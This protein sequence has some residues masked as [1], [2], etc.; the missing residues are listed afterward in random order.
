MAPTFPCSGGRIYLTSRASFKGAG[1]PWAVTLQCFSIFFFSEN[2]KANIS[3]KTQKAAPLQKG[4]CPP[5][6]YHSTFFPCALGFRDACWFKKAPWGLLLPYIWTGCPGSLG[7]DARS[8]V[9]TAQNKQRPL[10]TSSWADSK[11][12]APLCNAII[13]QFFGMYLWTPQIGAY[14]CLKMK[15]Y[16]TIP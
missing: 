1:S 14:E 2:I 10:A 8:P 15:A 4:V 7:C 12:P 13:F 9:I 16:K 11:E 5:N 6:L 3:F